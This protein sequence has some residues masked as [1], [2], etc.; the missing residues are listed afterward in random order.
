MQAADR[1][2][3]LGALKEERL[4]LESKIRDLEALVRKKD[5]EIASLAPVYT[6]SDDV[7]AIILE[8]AYRHHFPHCRLD[9]GHPHTNS[10]IPISH[11]SRWWRRQALSLPFLWSCIHVTSAQPPFHYAEA[12]KAYIERSSQLPLSISFL[13]L[14]RDYENATKDMPYLDDAEFFGPIWTM[15]AR[16]WRY[17]LAEKHR[18]KNCAMYL[19]HE[20]P[21]RALLPS[22]QGR[23]FPRLE[24]LGIACYS[25]SPFPDEIDD[26]V[27]TLDAPNLIELRAKTLPSIC[28]APSKLFSRLTELNLCGV[29]CSVG[30]LMS[31]LNETTGTLE[32]FTLS[33]AMFVRTSHTSFPSPMTFTKLSYLRLD[34]VVDSDIDGVPVPNRITCPLIYRA[35]VVLKTLAADPNAVE[36]LSRANVRL[37]TVKQLHLLKGDRK[38]LPVALLRT[39]PNIELL[40]TRPFWD[41]SPLLK[42][43]IEADR[44]SGSCVSWPHLQSLLLWTLGRTFGIFA[45][46]RAH[47][48]KPLKSC[49]C[50]KDPVRLPSD[51]LEIFQQVGLDFESYDNASPETQ[52][53]YDHTN[54]TWDEEVD[55]PIYTPWKGS[56]TFFDEFDRPKGRPMPRDSWLE[57]ANLV[58]DAEPWFEPGHELD[59]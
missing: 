36:D 45:Q 32:R 15:Y 43:S 14:A 11:V 4:Q 22:L 49:I 37:P 54:Q 1:R 57:D 55:K 33:D 44:S 2:A 50:R 25:S 12:V 29:E 41:L 51:I 8:L 19:F 27:L 35:A 46:H 24:Y 18:W 28:A 9:D 17:L 42:A 21:A 6:L 52:A 47:F 40:S 39:I 5:E 23:T 34:G 16:S 48:G 38:K 58:G 13:C 26:I 3:R 30:Q 10:P 7:V 59:D 20:D 56:Y 53:L 31:A